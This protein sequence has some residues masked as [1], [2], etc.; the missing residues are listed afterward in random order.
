[1]NSLCLYPYDKPD[2]DVLRGM[3]FSNKPKLINFLRQSLKIHT[4]G[5]SEFQLIKLLRNTDLPE[6]SLSI[7]HDNLALFRAHFFLF[8]SLYTLREEC[9][10]ERLGHLVI[11][12]I[13]II[14]LPYQEGKAEVIAQRDRLRDYYMD[15]ANIETTAED[16]DNMLGKFWSSLKNVDRKQQALEV[17]DLKEPVDYPAIKR[18]YRRLVM[19]HHPDR[20]GNKQRLQNINNAMAILEKRYK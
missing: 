18:Q 14:L 12:S 5:L 15:E 19:R 6:F 10:R 9:W 20:G 16:I 1:M 2:N 4:E 17:L 13:K 7:R 3:P 11:S 8:H